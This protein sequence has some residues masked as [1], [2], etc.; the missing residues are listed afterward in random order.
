MNT[1]QSAA[2]LD[3]PVREALARHV[4][5]LA[6]SKRL[7]GIRFSD[8]LL[9]APSIE[10][11]IAASGMAQDEWGHARLLYAMLKDLD[12]DPQA[13]EHERPAGEYASMDPLDGPLQDWAD[14]VAAMVVVDG[15]LT[16]ALEGFAA[17]RYEPAQSRIPKM[18]A[19]E[20]F[21]RDLGHAWARSLGAGTPEAVQRLG[22]ALRDLLPRTL[23]WL[24]PD[25]EAHRRLAEAGLQLS[26]D[27]LLARFRKRVAPALAAAGVDSQG[28]PERSE[29]D[30]VRGR[31]PGA[32]DEEA[33][34]RVRGDRNRALFVE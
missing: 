26:A 16:V 11:G 14:V 20:A 13:L 5:T 2:D 29:W 4:L 25:D 9:G 28:E 34:E 1:V 23:A 30:S 15:A 17:G 12:Q 19:E 18:V 32:P 7:L 22:D 3:A 27:E 8:W 10:T 31:G 33:V 21:H 24:A 6:D